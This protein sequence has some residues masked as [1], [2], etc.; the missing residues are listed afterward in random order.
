MV[1]SSKTWRSGGIDPPGTRDA[2]GAS[3][4]GT[5]VSLHHQHTGR[6]DAQPSVRCPTQGTRHPANTIG[7]RT[8][9]V[10]QQARAICKPRCRTPSASAGLPSGRE[11]TDT[12]RHA[13]RWVLIGP[14]QVA[15]R[16]RRHRLRVAC[17]GD[18]NVVVAGDLAAGGIEPLPTGPRQVDLGPGMGRGV[19]GV[20][21]GGVQIAADEATG[22][23]QMAASIQINPSP[24]RA[25]RLV[26]RRPRSKFRPLELAGCVVRPSW[27]DTVRAGSP[28]YACHWPG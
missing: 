10:R 19:A 18:R 20:A 25:R 5:T 1:D 28:D 4:C 24:T 12:D 7:S 13:Q 11:R 23:P 14:A 15:S 17:H 6:D 2:V 27:P 26:L 16:H 21:A 22:E 9:M 8:R 3:P